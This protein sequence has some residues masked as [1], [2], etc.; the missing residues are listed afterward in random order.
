MPFANYKAFAD[1]LGKNLYMPIMGGGGASLTSS[2]RVA[3]AWGTFLPVGGAAGVTPTASVALTA[4]DAGAINRDVVAA[5]GKTVRLIGGELQPTAN[6]FGQHILIDRLVHSGGLS[7]AVA[8]A[9]TTNLPTAALPRFTNGDGV[10][11]GLRI[12]TQIGATATTVTASYTNQAGTPGRTTPAV[13][14]GG[15]SF[16]E[17]TR[18]LVLPLQDGDT[19]VRSVESVTLAA[20]TDTAGNF[21]VVLFKPLAV[22]PQDINGHAGVRSAVYGGLFGGMPDISNACLS[23]LMIASIGFGDGPGR[24]G[25][26]YGID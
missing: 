8:T 9:Q 18:L 6:V 22:L 12:W 7:G 23:F 19:G 14:I 5:E 11:I 16:R 3:D 4:T 15:G 21:G 2:G 20:T 1:E 17:A 10:M 25:L 13:V 26:Y 24:G